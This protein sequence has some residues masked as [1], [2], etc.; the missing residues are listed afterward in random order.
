MVD[1]N[2][3]IVA[4]PV[5]QNK[6]KTSIPISR[7]NCIISKVGPEILGALGEPLKEVLEILNLPMCHIFI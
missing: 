5:T 1:V 2:A 7:P 4:T 6:A 3:T